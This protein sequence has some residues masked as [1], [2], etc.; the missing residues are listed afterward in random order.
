MKCPTC[1]KS[2]WFLRTFC[3]FCKAAIAAPPRPK[4]VAVIS[5]IALVVGGIMF[6]AMMAPNA[7]RSLAD[8]RSQHAFLYARLCAGPVVAV[9]C[10]VDASWRQ[11][12]TLA[13]G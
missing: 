7:Q 5:W 4:S 9:I 13:S 6:L 12:G 1:G 10:G 2:L 8:Y 11:L 3:P